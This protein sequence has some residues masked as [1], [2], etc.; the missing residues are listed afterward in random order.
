[1][2]FFNFS[3]NN[4]DFTILQKIKEVYFLWIKISDNIP[5]K[6]Q[7]TL[8]NKVENK[9]LELLEMS[10]LSYFSKDNKMEKISRCIIILDLLKFNISLSWEAKLIPSKQYEEISIL[11]AEVGKMMGGWKNSLNNPERKN[12]SL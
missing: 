5:K 8:G 6:R 4:F 12:H 9:I 11:L 10:Y 7:Y 3:H 1:M 2:Q